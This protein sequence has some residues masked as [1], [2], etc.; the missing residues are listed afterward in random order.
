[1]N[2]AA[3]YLRVSTEDQTEYSPDA[4]LREM[5]QYAAAHGI[6]IDPRYIFSDEGISGR[7]AEKRPGFLEMIRTAKRADHPFSI[8]LVHKFDRFARSRE[9]SVVYKSI[10][11]R[12]GVSVV[13]V[14]EPIS[15]GNY[16]GVMEA[17]YESFAEAYSINLSQEVKKGMTEKALRGQLQ[18]SPPY[19]YRAKDHCLVPN[20]EEADWVRFLFAG[21]S[22]GK[23]CYTLAKELNSAGQRTH[24][25]NPF[26]SRGVEYILRNPVYIG[27]LRWNPSGRLGRGP[28]NAE[29]IVV[30]GSHPP[31]IDQR[32][33]QH[34]QEMLQKKKKIAASHA[35]PPSCRKHWLSGL[36]RCANCE[37]ALIWT[38]PG[39]YRCGRYLRGSCTTSQH[40]SSST[41]ES[42]VWQA[43]RVHL[44]HVSQPS[45]R[46]LHRNDEKRNI[47]QRQLAHLKTREQRIQEGFLSGL[48]DANQAK[49][50]N[51]N[52]AGELN[53]LMEKKREYE[54]ST[55]HSFEE[56]VRSQLL[57][58]RCG[59]IP[60]EFSVDRLY[61]AV[62]CIVASVLVSKKDNKLYILYRDC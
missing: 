38:K 46:A 15:E 17:I 59:E 47:I 4:Q 45:F 40:I 57:Q 7:S 62:S 32:L 58:I 2:T 18:T 8:I 20:P 9:D 61:S 12:C 55:Q 43:L 3:V 42:L 34:V 35:R 24:R 52:L 49:Q 56:D 31:L 30:R 44:S 6:R 13:S 14:K 1:M 39:Y 53:E 48:F 27:F 25:G 5:Q 19:G 36:L 50:L 41:A 10:L 11:R 29:R 51:Q 23:S 26:E 28:D 33:W 21:F 54:A 22:D 16:A 37:A 60:L